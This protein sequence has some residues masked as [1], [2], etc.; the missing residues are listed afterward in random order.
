VERNFLL[1]VASTLGA[2]LS[3]RRTL[4]CL[5]VL[6]AGAVPSIALADSAGDSQ[7]TDPFGNSGSGTTKKKSTKK[8]TAAPT[9]SSNSSGGSGGSSGSTGSGSSS[10]GTSTPSSG[11]VAG[12]STSGATGTASGTSTTGTSTT[13]TT[14]NGDLPHT[15]D[16]PFWPGVAG[17]FLLLS[18]VGLRMRLRATRGD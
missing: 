14:A 5:L 9:G 13:S 18:G 16:D 2:M 1:P 3:P 7:Y 4:T 11:A 15:G 8:S 17:G 6:A 12:T 10:G